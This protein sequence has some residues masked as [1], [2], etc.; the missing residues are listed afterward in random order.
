[1]ND[2]KEYNLI[3]SNGQLVTQ[4][5]KAIKPLQNPYG[6]YQIIPYINVGGWFCA[7]SYNGQVHNLGKTWKEMFTENRNILNTQLFMNIITENIDNIMNTNK[8]VI[9]LTEAKLMNIIEE[10]V[11]KVL[12]E[13]SPS[14]ENRCLDYLREKGFSKDALKKVTISMYNNDCE[15][16]KDGRRE[17]LCLGINQNGDLMY[18]LNQRGWVIV[19]ED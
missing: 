13:Q 9:R 1:M 17:I 10:S 19:N 3:D 14:F 7:L 2:R 8:K 16:L 4:W 5:F 11:R 6:K 15:V 12:K 18:S